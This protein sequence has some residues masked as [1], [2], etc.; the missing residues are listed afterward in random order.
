MR[1][2]LSILGLAL[3]V[4][5]VLALAAP[6]SEASAS[7]RVH[8]VKYGETLYSIA[9]MYGTSV[10]ALAQSNGLYNPNFVQ[11]GRCLSVPAG[12]GAGYGYGY[13]YGAGYGYGHGYGYK[14]PDYGYTPYKPYQPHYGYGHKG[15]VHCMRYGETLYGVAYAYGVS[16]WSLAN[17]NGIYNPNYVRAG[18]CLRIPGY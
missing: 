1:T 13:G 12:Y 15:G 5:A 17:A 7:G 14:K 16:V 9:H 2:R 18:A 8:C 10:H 11:A 4:T 3:L 6:T